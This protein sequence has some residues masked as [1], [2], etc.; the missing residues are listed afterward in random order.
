[1]AGADTVHLMDGH[2][3]FHPMFLQALLAPEIA[4]LLSADAKILAS[5]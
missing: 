2:K 1:M 3:V 5:K 4:S